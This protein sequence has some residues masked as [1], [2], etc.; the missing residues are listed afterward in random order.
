MQSEI[1]KQII[2]KRRSIYPKDY[3]GAAIPDEVLEEILNSANFAPNHKKTRPW[4][5]KVFRGEEKTVL[6]Q[7]IAELYK[8]STPPQLFVEKKYRDIPDKIAKSNAVVSICVNFSG[9]LPEWEE[10]AATAMAV[11]NMYLTSTAQN[12]GCYWSSHAVTAQLG[13]FLNLE[14]N[15]KCLGLFYM[16][17]I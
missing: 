7:T 9:L 5:F 13:K 10:I 3:T 15:Q 12:V 2:E 11:Q 17:M 16:G 4:L 8:N 14:E 6:G 1:L